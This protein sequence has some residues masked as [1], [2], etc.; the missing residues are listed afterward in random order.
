MNWMNRNG[1]KAIQWPFY[2]VAKLLCGVH[3]YVVGSP[4]R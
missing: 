1:I 4:V 2:T 3:A